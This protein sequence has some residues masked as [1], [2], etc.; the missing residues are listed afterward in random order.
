VLPPAGYPLSLASWSRALRADPRALG[1]FQS[2]LEQRFRVGGSLLVSSGRA[3]LSVGLRALAGKSNRTVVVIPAYACYT[4]PASVVRAGL[5]VRLCDVDPGTLDFD[6]D[7]LRRVLHDDVLAVVAAGLYGLP[8]DV[9]ALSGRAR[10][11]G[12][13][14]VDDA[15]QG[16]GGSIAGAVCGSQGDFG[17][18]S[19][20]K[21]KGLSTFEGGALLSSD[22]DLLERAQQEFA[23]E[24]ERPYG[25]ASMA[26]RSMGFAVFQRPRLYGLVHRIPLLGLGRSVF[27]PGFAIGPLTAFQG[28][29][30]LEAL[31]RA[32][33]VIAAR[34]ARAAR[35][36][37]AL[38]HV[39]A[40]HLPQAH[41]EAVP[42]WT[43]FPV[44]I[45]DAARRRDRLAQL[46]ATGLGASASYPAAL[47]QLKELWPHLTRRDRCPGAEHIAAAIVTLPT[48]PA[49]T[50]GDQAR[51]AGILAGDPAAGL[52]E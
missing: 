31:R 10:S 38:E 48:H 18:T 23:T 4:V 36:K 27:D 45:G 29:L 12:A 9:A 51:I 13:H 19:F 11:V 16:F 26:V 28:G 7:A 47:S 42:A 39:P 52:N 50:T 2:A 5:R 30:G 37:A 15:A 17:I 24:R 35:Y 41:P 14:V 33:D 20:S 40:M 8:T 49:V 25:T 46:A 44:L 6:Q 22:R 3:A 43:R 1:D 21:G 34:R 32:D